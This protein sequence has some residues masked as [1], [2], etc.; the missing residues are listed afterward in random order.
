MKQIIIKSNELT[1][2]IDPLGAELAS[3]KDRQDTEHLWQGDERFWTSR[4]PVLFPIVGGLK[5]DRYEIDGKSFELDKHG[6]ARLRVFTVAEQSDASVLM[7]LKADVETRNA[8]PFDFQLSIRYTVCANSLA[9]DYQID[10]CS[11]QTLYGSIG[12]HEG[13][14]CPE[15]FEAYDLLF[16]Q[17]ETLRTCELDG[18]LLN[19]DTTVVLEK[20]S[21]LPLQTAYF[22]VDALV[23]ATIRSQSVTLA[24]RDGGRRIRVDFPGFPSLGIWTK[25]GAPYLCIEPWCGLPDETSSTGRIDEKRGILAVP[26]QRSLSR[27]H[28]ITID[29]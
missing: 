28:T 24:R 20:G 16:E 13:Y 29:T 25:P 18:N 27:S 19:G 3:I 1:V 22:A 10:N 5:A 17:E 21:V 23:F 6:F 12:A 9:V 14:F 2:A 8:Y 15:G 4:A 7:T 11:N 26:A